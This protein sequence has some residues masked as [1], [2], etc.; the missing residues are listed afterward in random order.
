M[1]AEVEAVLQTIAS[2]P[3][4]S[5][6]IT[7]RGQIPCP[8]IP[9][10]LPHPT[11]LGP[12]SLDAAR[13][14]FTDINPEVLGDP[15]LDELLKMLDCVPL[16]VTILAALSQLG[17]TPLELAERFK[18]ERSTLLRLG[19]D[20][21]QSVEIS[22]FLSL[23]SPPMKANPEALILLQILSM[24]PGG[25][26]ADRLPAMAPALRQLNTALDTLARVYLASTT[27]DRIIRVLSP[28][29]SYMLEY[30]QLTD[31]H[32]RSLYQCYYDLA[33]RS[34]PTGKPGFLQIKREM[35]NEEANMDNILISALDEENPRAAIVASKD[36]T[37]FLFADVSRSE[38][39]LKAIKISESSENSDLLSDC[40]F[41][42]GQIEQA[43]GHYDVAIG[44]IS[45]A[46]DICEDRQNQI[47]VAECLQSWG[48]IL[49]MQNQYDN[50]QTLLQDAKTKFHELG[51][52]VGEA[53]CIRSLGSILR[54]QGELWSP[55]AG[56][57]KILRF[58]VF[59]SSRRGSK[60][61]S[62]CEDQ[63]P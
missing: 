54:M 19:D 37:W 24:L 14:T 25:A 10:I 3:K 18:S 6:L 51:H 49:R 55:N 13:Q 21:L 63:T 31:L 53:R 41:V 12:L 56:N 4:V 34:N 20:R 16:A 8:N 33:R 46:K 58:F 45:R 39:I 61:P 2:Y 30:Y 50:A 26:K 17:E 48:N 43:R 38:V 36:Y 57:R 44:D 1:T 59:R 40:L 27:P 9:W 5:I 7:T 28:I 60:L 42:K 47:G 29:R 23:S 22:V 35:E 62:R 52:G 32:R 15:N 11:P